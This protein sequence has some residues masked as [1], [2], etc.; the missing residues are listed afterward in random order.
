MGYE[1]ETR[2]SSGVAKAGLT[3]GIIGTSL[4]GLLA[5]NNGV[6]LGNIFGGGNNVAE[7]K[8]SKIA[9]LE[10]KVAELKGMRYTDLVGIDLY[11]S[12]VEAF[13][14]EDAKIGAVQSEMIKYVIDLDKR[15]ALNA[16]AQELNRAYDTMARDYQM[17]ILNNKIDCCCEKMNMQTAFD[18]H[19]G[20]LADSSIIS[21]VNSNFVPGTLK[22]P[23]T[24]ICPQPAP[25]T[26]TA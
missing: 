21:W 23:I 8:D 12:T 10:S 20:T 14:E 15:T 24:S 9:C 25:A 22:L 26:T 16:Q 4:A 19:L 7:D 5:G 6:G 3:L 2:H 1:N 17:T 13:K 18:R 11:K